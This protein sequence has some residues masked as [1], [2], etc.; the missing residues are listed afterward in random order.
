MTRLTSSTTIPPPKPAPRT[1]AE[2]IRRSTSVAPKKKNEST[3]VIGT[4]T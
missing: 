4:Y 2:S 1:K 3:V